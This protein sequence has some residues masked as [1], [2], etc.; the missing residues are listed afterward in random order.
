MSRPLSGTENEEVR[1]IIKQFRNSSL[2]GPAGPTGSEGQQGEQGPSGA[3]GSKGDPGTSVLYASDWTA[4]A[5]NQLNIVRY[6][7]DLYIVIDP[8]GSTS[9][10][11]L[12]VSSKFTLVSTKGDIG[13]QGEQGL[14]GIQGYDGLSFTFKNN[15]SAQA[16]S[17]LDSIFYT[18]NGTSY[19]M[20]NVNGCIA[21]DIPGISSKWVK[22]CEGLSAADKSTI[23]SHMI[24]STNPHNVT[25]TQTLGNL[26][27]TYSHGEIDT[28]LGE[29]TT[30]M[31]ST[32]T[33]AIKIEPLSEGHNGNV[34]VGYGTTNFNNGT[35]NTCVGTLSR[36]NGTSGIA[37]TMI[38]YASGANCN[39]SCNTFLGSQSGMSNNS[40]CVCLGFNAIP[41]A[42]SQFLLHCDNK[43]LAKGDFI[44]Q[45]FEVPVNLKTPLIQPT[46]SLDIKLADNAGAQK[47][48]IK[49]SDNAVVASIDSN[50]NITA[51]GTI[52]DISGLL[53]F[54]M[55]QYILTK[56]FFLDDFNRSSGWNDQ[57][58]WI[59]ISTNGSGGLV[60]IPDHPDSAMHIIANAA[61]P[62]SAQMVTTRQFSMFVSRGYNIYFSLYLNAFAADSVFSVNFYD[63]AH[64]CTLTL[65]RDGS[66]GYWA[67]KKYINAGHE[68]LYSLHVANANTKY[69]FKIACTA[70]DISFY[71]LID[72]VFTLIK[73]YTALALTYNSEIQLKTT[74]LE[75]NVN[76]V[77]TQATDMYVDFVMWERDRM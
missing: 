55:S 57:G 39:G 60:T 71:I 14:Q 67:T 68:T 24:S 26:A 29:F 49:D 56:E 35:T 75:F 4:Q 65:M 20:S 3:Q 16:Y 1:R 11:V 77:S 72:G 12:G 58:D 59:W 34:L 53:R 47:L 36:N 64:N 2:R 18:T 33:G 13:P 66:H 74:D 51:S 37:N 23:S 76:G 70:T 6:N 61:S 63:I 42:D 54:N 69:M 45:V 7:G 73:S 5:Y 50:G 10:D 8:N 52:S 19:W 28:K 21:S 30:F 25:H 32:S 62:S 31:T 22:M 44:N 48:N 41:T 43:T 17:Y 46:A 9:E 15:W 40:Y 27:P 38:G